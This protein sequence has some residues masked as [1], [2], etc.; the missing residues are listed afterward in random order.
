MEAA[1]AAGP[2]PGLN[3]RLPTTSAQTRGGR[4]QR[5]H[6]AHARP[7]VALYLA[8]EPAR[9]EEPRDLG[10]RAAVRRQARHRRGA[11]HLQMGDRCAGRPRHRAARAGQRHRLGVGDA[12]DDDAGLWR[13]AHPD[14]G[15]HPVAR[16]HF[17]QGG[18]ERGAAAGDA[19]LRSYAHAVVALSSRAQDRRTDARSR[20]RP[21]RHRDH[22]AHG[23]AATG[24]DRRRARP[25]RRRAA[26]PFRLALRCRDH[27]HGR[28][29]YV[30]HLSRHRM[31]HQHPPRDEFERHRRQCQGDRLAAQLRNG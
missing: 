26:V 2:G 11:V 9:P 30:V 25:D 15:A 10:D 7:F 8:G 24:A 22:R 1:R 31:A 16:R 13:H 6:A 28:A 3:E 29:L 27:D 5:R 19:H 23:A 14:G 17:R 20:T 18:H 12:G 21:Q 4:R